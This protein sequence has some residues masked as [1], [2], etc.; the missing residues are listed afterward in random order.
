MTSM[1]HAGPAD[2]EF[3]R[4]RRFGE[5]RSVVRSRGGSS[6]LAEA[7]TGWPLDATWE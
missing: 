6:Y 4:L 1:L 5:L 2:T 3:D 7:Y